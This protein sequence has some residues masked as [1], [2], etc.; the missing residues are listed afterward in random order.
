MEYKV[1]SKDGLRIPFMFVRAG[2]AFDS[3]KTNLS[4]AQLDEMVKENLI[5]EIKEAGGEN[6]PAIPNSNIP[7]SN[8]NKNN[9]VKDI[10]EVKNETIPSKN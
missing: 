3:S 4:Q 2:N 7:K 8:Y 6:P 5:E 10:K 9:K 1:I